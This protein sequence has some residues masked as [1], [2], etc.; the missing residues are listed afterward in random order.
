[1]FV[2]KMWNKVTNIS[3]SISDPWEDPARVA[4]SVVCMIKK[5]K[6]RVIIFFRFLVLVLI[7]SDSGG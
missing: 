4:I 6:S 5:M 7:F 3:V 1:M 2:D